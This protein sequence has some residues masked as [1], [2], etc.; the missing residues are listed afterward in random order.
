MELLK[1]IK[2]TRLFRMLMKSRALITN[3]LLLMITSI[4]MIQYLFFQ[5]EPTNIDLAILIMISFLAS[6]INNK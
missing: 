6:D 5:V 3:T 2:E 1:T 4:I